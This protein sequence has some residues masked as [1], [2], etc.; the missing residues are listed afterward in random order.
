MNKRNR[1]V[2]GHR[3]LWG[4]EN[5]GP[6]CWTS[7]APLH[8]RSCDAETSLTEDLFLSPNANVR[9]AQRNTIPSHANFR[10]QVAFS[11]RGCVKM[12]ISKGKSVNTLAKLLQ[13][14]N[15]AASQIRK[16]LKDDKDK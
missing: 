15:E 2:T 4:N 3:R 5:E 7:R 6:R 9:Y 8:R 14:N 12:S 1:E 13:Q 16:D 10:S 11:K